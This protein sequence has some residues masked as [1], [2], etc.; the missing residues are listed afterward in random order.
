MIETLH[1]C[2]ETKQIEKIKDYE[3]AKL[4]NYLAD[5][6]LDLHVK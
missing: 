4:Q 1:V 5:I 6:L 2:L 3:S